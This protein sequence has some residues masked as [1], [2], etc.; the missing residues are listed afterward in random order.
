MC[1][2]YDSEMNP[3]DMVYNSPAHVDLDTFQQDMNDT[4]MY[5]GLRRY[6]Q[7]RRYTQTLP[8]HSSS[9]LDI[10]Y[11]LLR[12]VR[13]SCQLDS[14]DMKLTQLVILC[15]LDSD[16]RDHLRESKSSTKSELIDLRSTTRRNAHGRT[17]PTIRGTLVRAVARW[18]GGTAKDEGAYGSRWACAESWQEASEKLSLDLL[19]R[20]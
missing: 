15:R 7:N 12:S 17:L 1:D 19:A 16:S 14:L 6:R 5:S 11:T 3:P 2:R 4:L 18:T 13:I 10:V 9:R 20:Q 8:H